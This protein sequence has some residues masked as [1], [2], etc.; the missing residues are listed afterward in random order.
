MNTEDSAPRSA[1]DEPNAR[2]PLGSRGPDQVDATRT[3]VFGRGK[4]EPLDVAAF[5]SFAE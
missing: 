2:A 4:R 3:R 1:R 5:Q